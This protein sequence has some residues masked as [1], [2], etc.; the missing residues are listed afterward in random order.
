MVVLIYGKKR[1][2]KKRTDSFTSSTYTTAQPAK[3]IPA[4]ATLFNTLVS[5]NTLFLLKN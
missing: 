1:R 3:T 5:F 2:K 4:T